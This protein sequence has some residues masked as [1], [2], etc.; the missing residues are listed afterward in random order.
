[1]RLHAYK[2]LASLGLAVIIAATGFTLPAYA[3]LPYQTSSTDYT[4]KWIPSPDAYKPLRTVEGLS[5]PEDLFIT[6]E[7]ELYVADTKNDRI[8]HLDAQG[9]VLRYIPSETGEAGDGEKKAR[10]RRPEGI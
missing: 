3:V 4:G 9:Q 1:M 5:G 2:L 10:L 7:D 6:A 8:V